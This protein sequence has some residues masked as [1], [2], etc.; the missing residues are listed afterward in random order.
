MRGPDLCEDVS[1]TDP[2]STGLLPLKAKAL[3]RNANDTASAVNTFI[4]IAKELLKTRGKA[5]MALLRGFSSPPNLPNMGEKYS[6]TPAAIASYPMYRGL[7]KLAG[8]SILKTGT[9]FDDQISTLEN[10]ISEHDFF[11]LHYKPADTAGEDGDF[12]AKVAALEELDAR[13]PRLIELNPDVLVIAGDHSTPSIMGR[14]SW[15]PVPLLVNSSIPGDQVREFTE[16]AC[17]TGSIGR[18][19]ATNLM[20]ITLAHADKLLKFG[21]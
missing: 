6:L 13:I 1:E 16:Q 4:G 18:I 14:H 10:H 8:M 20:M 19:P 17:S 11:F 12:E 21:P 3:S 7:S 9:N 2:Q 5:N 15:H